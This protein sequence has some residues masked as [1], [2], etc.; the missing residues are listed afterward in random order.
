MP[1]EALLAPCGPARVHVV[2]PA[3]NDGDRLLA[4]LQSLLA[5]TQ[6]ATRIIVV[7]DASTD[8]AVERAATQ[9]PDIDVL[10]NKT[11]LGFGA[12][13]NRGIERAIEHDA[14]YVL[15]LNQDTTVAPDMLATLV[16][17]GDAHPAAGCIAPKTLATQP[18]PD[19]TPQLL[20]AGAWRRWLPLRQHVPG[21]G[22]ADRATVTSPIKV[23]Y[24][25]GHGMLL[26]TTALR[27][28][29]LFDPNFF[30]YY[31][32]ID[33]CLRLHDAGWQIWCEPR[34]VMWHDVADGARAADSERW[35]WRNKVCSIRHLHR[36]RFS[37]SKAAFLTTATVLAEILSLLRNGHPRAAWHLISAAFEPRHTTETPPSDS[38]E[39]DRPNANMMVAPCDIM[40]EPLVSVVIPTYARPERLRECLAALAR[41]TIPADSFEIVVVDDGSPQPVVPPEAT[42]PAG[43][44]I[45]VIRQPNAGPSAA[46]NRGVTEARGELI[47]LTDDDCLP[48]PTWLESLVTVHRQCPDALVGGITFNGLTDD[49]FATT[50]QMIIDLVYEH[51]NADEAAAY[52]LTSN[53]VLCSRADYR[54]LGGFDTSFQRAGAEDRDFCDRW[55]ASG[56]PLRLVTSAHIEH[57]HAQTLKQFLGLHY[58]YGRGAYLYQAKRRLRGSGTMS[59][60]MNFHRRLLRRLPR[61]LQKHGG[62]VWKAQIATAILLWQAANAIGFFDEAAANAFRRKPLGK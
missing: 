39:H 30:M 15:L 55:R 26:R 22:R 16:A 25:W 18:M 12:T 5:S 11:N 56:K 29:G 33:L 54:E 14:D 62:L 57:R 32:D 8:D 4:C 10:R 43:P 42:T 1:Q 23:D 46:R 7:D 6:Q 52:F 47:A 27:N 48:T 40:N 51:F 59:H 34:G 3:H 36:K 20:Y 28:V 49:V 38:R 35:R 60:D 2:I 9:S 24:A 61:H 31:E 17:C 50:S 45:R 41:Q 13:C 19:G 53:N 21:T 37:R 58:R 44:T